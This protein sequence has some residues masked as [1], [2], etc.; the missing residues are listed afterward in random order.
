MPQS[1]HRSHAS[2]CSSNPFM[3][4]T[5]PSPLPPPPPLTL[6]PQPPPNP[7]LTQP[8]QHQQTGPT[9]G[10]DV[11]WLATSCGKP[12]QSLPGCGRVLVRLQSRPRVA[13]RG[14]DGHI[15]VTCNSQGEKVQECRSGNA[16]GRHGANTECGLGGWGCELTCGIAEDC[17]WLELRAPDAARAATRM[18]NPWL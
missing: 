5:I 8:L 3:H 10:T 7:H 11:R 15:C 9:S 1:S 18:A 4:P 2:S 6:P 13:P 17:I 16:G 14:P 12:A